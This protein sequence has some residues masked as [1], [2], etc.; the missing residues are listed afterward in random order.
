M[1]RDRCVQTLRLSPSPGHGGLGSERKIGRGAGSLPPPRVLPSLSPKEE[2]SMNFRSS[3]DVSKE[4]RAGLIELLNELLANS[5]DLHSQAKQAHWNV[6]GRHFISAHELFED[7]AKHTA[8]HSDD[9]AERVAALGGYALGTTRQ[10]AQR[11]RLDEFAPSS[12][13][14]Q[15][16][17]SELVDRL[18]AHATLLR[19]G[20][21]QT[22]GD[23]AD[24]VTEDLLVEVLR[25]VEVDLWFLESHLDDPRRALPSTQEENAGAPLS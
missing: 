23:L 17:L 4:K 9:I 15:D 18:A 1:G 16:C 6:K 22:G 20:I 14:G 7:V 11:T 24:P 5:L 8:A 12:L 10:V 13:N 25:E 21:E 19:A 3:V 2:A